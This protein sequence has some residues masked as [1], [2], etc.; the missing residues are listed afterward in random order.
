MVQTDTRSLTE[1]IQMNKVLSQRE[2]VFAAIISVFSDFEVDFEE[3]Q[4]AT[5]MLTKDM[6]SA[7]QAILVEGFK[8]GTV[9]FE[10]TPSNQEKLKTDSKLKSYVSGLVSNW[11]RKDKRLNGNV[12]YVAKNPG[13]RAG[14]GD[15]TLKTMRLLYKQYAADPTKAAA[16][17]AQIDKRISEISASKAKTITVTP[18]QIDKL[19]PELKAILFPSN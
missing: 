8:G 19:S 7:V 4:D 9:E 11:L 2:A 10:A 6:R 13:S 12:T 16:I 18:E 17:Q 14:S 3:G 5:P 15:E 1:D